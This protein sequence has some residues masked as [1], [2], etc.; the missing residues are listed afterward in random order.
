MA[1][2]IFL[3]GASGYIGGTVLNHLAKSHPDYDIVALARTPTQAETI[4]TT[5]PSITTTIGSLDTSDVLVT[6]ASRSSIVLQ[7][8]D[9]DHNAGTDALITALA[10]AKAKKKFYIHLS[11][12]ANLLDLT[13]APGLPA[14]RSWTDTTDLPTISTFP[15]T[16]IHAAIEQRITAFG[17]SNAAQGLRVAIVSPPGVVGIGT[18]PLKKGASSYVARVLERKRAFVVGEGSNVFDRVSVH[19]LASA[20][21]ALVEAAV[22][23]LGGQ[24][25]VADWNEEGYYFVTSSHPSPPQAEYASTVAR[26]L[27]EKGAL[28]SEELDRIDVEEASK[29]H[30]YGAIMWGGAISCEGRRLRETLGWESRGGN[31]DEILREEVTAEIERHKRG[32][33][34]AVGFGQ[35]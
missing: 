9:A 18:G 25:P 10:S 6:E 34:M 31:W 4:K 14:P 32:E 26:I 15:H 29:L 17:V 16:Q 22:K 27:R 5:Y 33:K 23:E 30:P 13:L 24:M 11:G 12:A 35:D 19:D 1:P 2:R 7:L 21:G 20:I 8:A 28:E 3:L